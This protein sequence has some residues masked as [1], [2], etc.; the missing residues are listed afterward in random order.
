MSTE[1]TAG[2]PPP[3]TRTV[4]VPGD[5]TAEME[6]SIPVATSPDVDPDRGLTVAPPPN[7]PGVSAISRLGLVAAGVPVIVMVDCWVTVME[8]TSTSLRVE[9]IPVA[10]DDV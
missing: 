3:S 10:T 9:M 6:A 7:P 4:Y 2:A 1:S 5:T 8:N